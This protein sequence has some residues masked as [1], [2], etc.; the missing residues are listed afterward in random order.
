M[1]CYEGFQPNVGEQ[2]AGDPSSAPTFPAPEHR[3]AE[4]GAPAATLPHIENSCEKCKIQFRSSGNTPRRLPL[5]NRFRVLLESLEPWGW[6]R[7]RGQL[8]HLITCLRK[9][10]PLLSHSSLL[11]TCPRLS[12]FP[13]WGQVLYDEPTGRLALVFE[14]MDMNAYEMIRGRRHYLTEPKVKVPARCL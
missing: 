14:L 10:V 4:R 5:R 3:Q 8:L 9:S 6:K 12:S 7:V 11:A 13:L 1:I 2:L